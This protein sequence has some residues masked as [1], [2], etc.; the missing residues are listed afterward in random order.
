MWVEQW[1]THAIKAGDAKEAKEEETL[2]QVLEKC[3]VLT[4]VPQVLLKMAICCAY[5][6]RLNLS[7][8]VAD[9]VKAALK[10]KIKILPVTDIRLGPAPLP[11]HTCS[12]L[13]E[14]CPHLNKLAFKKC[15]IHMNRF[16]YSYN[17][18]STYS[19]RRAHVHDVNRLLTTA[20]RT[21]TKLKIL[22]LSSTPVADEPVQE[23]ALR[24]HK[25]QILAVS[26]TCIT[27]E[28][29]V[30]IARNCRLLEQVFLA[31]TKITDTAVCELA[32]N[33]TALRKIDLSSTKVT[34]ASVTHLVANCKQLQHIDVR[35]TEVTAECVAPVAARE[36]TVLV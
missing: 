30:L 32:T 6:T 28:S 3:P 35:S 24:C 11:V 5:S 14:S 26:R 15:Q 21:C 34:D 19:V 1:D 12:L 31:S 16:S 2:L 29:I 36:G 8:M 20:V 17:H 18:H 25:L 7:H 23:A 13:F 10:A 27:D 22:S 4:K 33:C 9:E